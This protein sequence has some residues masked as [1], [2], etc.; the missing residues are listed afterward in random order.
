MHLPRKGFTLNT[1]YLQ[2]AETVELTWKD[3]GVGWSVLRICFCF[4]KYTRRKN[5]LFFVFFR[6]TFCSFVSSGSSS[7]P[8]SGFPSSRNDSG[9]R[10]G[11]SPRIRQSAISFSI[12]RKERMKEWVSPVIV[13]G[14]LLYL[15]ELQRHW[16]CH[17]QSEGQYGNVSIQFLWRWLRYYS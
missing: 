14:L 2:L 17:E 6:F 9:G 11:V 7:I 13:K 3:E 1:R 12:E 15:N 10:M 5:C 4:F 16:N 8:C